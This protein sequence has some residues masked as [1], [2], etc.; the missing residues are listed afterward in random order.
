[1]IVE[2]ENKHRKKTEIISNENNKKKNPK[3]QKQKFEIKFG[4]M[5]G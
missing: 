5:N 4:W 3:Q 1:M 2:F